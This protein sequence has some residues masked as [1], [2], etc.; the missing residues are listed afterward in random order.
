MQVY[1]NLFSG[2][3]YKQTCPVGVIFDPQLNT[4]AT[5][6]QEHREKLI[7]FLFL[8]S[9]DHFAYIFS[10]EIF[11]IQFH[12]SLISSSVKSERVHRRRGEL[13]WLPVSALCA[14]QVG[15]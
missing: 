2:T 9:I 14:R 15:A 12:F 7:V 8:K 5:P 3:A 6:D 4:C 11:S 1:Y 10:L 13:P